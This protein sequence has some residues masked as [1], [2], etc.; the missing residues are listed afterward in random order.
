MVSYQCSAY[1]ADKYQWPL[2]LNNT[3][4]HD[5]PIDDAAWLIRVFKTI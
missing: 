2:T 1:L 5:L 3:A 4:G